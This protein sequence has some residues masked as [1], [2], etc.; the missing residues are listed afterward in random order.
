MP[1]YKTHSIH[2]EIIFPNIQSKTEINL[3]D[4]KLYCIGPDTLITSDYKV[5]NKQHEYNVQNFFINL[6]KEINK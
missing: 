3:E 1:T 5:F 6:L 4:L 2:G